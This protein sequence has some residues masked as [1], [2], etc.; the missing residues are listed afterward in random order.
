MAYLR[1]MKV[2]K[3]QKAIRASHQLVQNLKKMEESGALHLDREKREIHLVRQIFW[4]GKD[5]AWRR[6]FTANLY[7]LLERHLDKNT[8]QPFHIYNIDIDTKERA[9]YIASYLPAE[10][11]CK[12]LLGN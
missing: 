1:G 10:K 11:K 2:S 8:G 12:E 9:E 3:T 7:F 4:D 6:N 5:L